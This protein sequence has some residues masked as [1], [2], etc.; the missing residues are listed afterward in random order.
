MLINLFKRLSQK[1]PQ[2]QK[3]GRNFFRPASNIKIEKTILLSPNS[4]LPPSVVRKDLF[5]LKF[6]I[7]M[8]RMSG[9]ARYF[10]KLE[11]PLLLE[12]ILTDLDKMAHLHPQLS[13]ILKND[14]LNIHNPEEASSAQRFAEAARSARSSQ[15]KN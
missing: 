11:Q 4:A 12:S 15:C 6:R 14:L 9:L 1:T 10:G 7:Q 3:R 13:A 8:A 2:L 5:D